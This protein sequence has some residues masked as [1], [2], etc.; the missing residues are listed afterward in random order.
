MHRNRMF[1][2][3]GMVR[4]RGGGGGEIVGAFSL[5]PGSEGEGDGVGVSEGGLEVGMYGL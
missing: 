5:H 1:G 3:E 2:H 4:R